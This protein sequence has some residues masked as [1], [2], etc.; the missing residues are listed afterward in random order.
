MA[1][2]LQTVVPDRDRLA[3]V[4][5]QLRRLPIGFWAQFKQLA[6]TYKALSLQATLPRLSAYL[7]VV[8]RWIFMHYTYDWMFTTTCV[9]LYSE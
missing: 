8:F 3:L 5:W 9:L 1:A 6:L 4:L 7:S 2:G